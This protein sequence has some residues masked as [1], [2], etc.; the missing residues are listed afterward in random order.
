VNLNHL[1]LTVPNVATARLFFEKH[2]NFKCIDVKGDN[3]LAVL[4]DSNGFIFT[5]MSE[6]FNKNGVS[7]YPQNFHFG[8]ILNSKD[9][10]NNLYKQ[11]KEDGIHLENEPSKIRN[12]FGFYFYFDNLFIEIGHYIT[13]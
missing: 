1:N 3:L 13:E 9:E 4:N 6:T 11:L 5:L 8:F 7:A 10:V 2:F 12:S